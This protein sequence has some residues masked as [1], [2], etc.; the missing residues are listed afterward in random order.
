MAAHAGET[1]RQTV[2]LHCGRCG[3][4]V[5]VR[6]GELI[7]PCPNGHTEFKKRMQDPGRR[8]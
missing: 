2:V 8:R 1:A 4:T 3:A 5:S 7:P 6:A